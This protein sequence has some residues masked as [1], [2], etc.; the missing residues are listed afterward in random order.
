M[1]DRCCRVRLLK[2]HYEDTD[3]KQRRLGEPHYGFLIESDEGLATRL[4]GTVAKFE[5]I[6]FS[7]LDI[8]QTARMNVFQY[9]IGNKDWSFVTSDNDDTCCHNIDRLDI[10]NSLVPIP[11]DFDLAA[12]TRANYRTKHELQQSTKREHKGYCRT[13]ADM[14]EQAIDQV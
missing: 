9:V 10:D 7:S 13:P 1:S 14:L 11:Y 2:I 5:S 3:G 4:G 12:L 8:Q 6:R